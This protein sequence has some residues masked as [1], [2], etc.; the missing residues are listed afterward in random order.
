MKWGAY[1]FFVFC[2]SCQVAA[3]N[4]PVVK[5]EAIPD[6][7]LDLLGSSA[8]GLKNLWHSLSFEET[9][10]AFSKSPELATS[11]HNIRLLKNIFLAPGTVKDGTA[12]VL[13]LARIERLI[14]IGALDEALELISM[15]PPSVR[16]PS[17]AKAYNDIMFYR[18]DDEKACLTAQDFLSLY[19]SRYFEEAFNFCLLLQGRKDQAY[20]GFALLRERYDVSSPYLLAADNI[21]NSAH[22][23]IAPSADMDGFSF[24]LYRFLGLDIAQALKDGG[25]FWAARLNARRDAETAEKMLNLG[26]VSADEIGYRDG[27]ERFSPAYYLS[28]MTKAWHS[29]LHYLAPYVYADDI[30][31]VPLNED[32]M[33]YAGIVIKSLLLLRHYEAAFEWYKKADFL[34]NRHPAAKKVSILYAPIF[35]F[36][37]GYGESDNIVITKYRIFKDSSRFDRQQTLQEEKILSN[38][39]TGSTQIDDGDLREA[40]KRRQKGSI[41]FLAMQKLNEN[42][43]LVDEV[44][45]ALKMAGFDD[46]AKTM[47]VDALVKTLDLEY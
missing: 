21:M 7:N 1:I 37:Q 31:G 34:A 13:F 46:I 26:L 25:K 40:A 22:N 29:G 36:L 35:K 4:A 6:I 42:P 8:D 20:V 43:L 41:L 23:D 10:T 3:Q 15:V 18:Q 30:M 19:K 33:D 11:P 24:A 9:L 16:T 28:F 45:A 38:I 44:Y 47:T 14:G 5:T 39:L 27:K 32:N 17:I 2:L 12:S